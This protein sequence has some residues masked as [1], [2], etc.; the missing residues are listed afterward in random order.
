MW[1]AVSSPIKLGQ[2]WLPN[3]PKSML[4]SIVWIRF[5]EAAAQPRATFPLPWH[6]SQGHVTRS[7]QWK[8]SGIDMLHFW[9]DGASGGPSHALPSCCVGVDEGDITR[10]S[11]RT[12]WFALDSISAKNKLWLFWVTEL[13]GLWIAAI[14]L[15][16]AVQKCKNVHSTFHLVFESH[17]HDSRCERHCKILSTR[18]TLGIVIG[19]RIKTY[20]LKIR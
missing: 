5:W 12:A 17:K 18:K 20:L 16:W 15:P 13:L 8:V 9:G 1:S 4:S 6:L 11:L 7:G 19:K 2:G 10:A 3:C 14:S